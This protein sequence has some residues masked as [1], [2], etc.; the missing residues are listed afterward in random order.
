[1][2]PVMLNSS[3]LTYRQRADAALADAS[4]GELGKCLG[5]R[6][7]CHFEDGLAAI[8]GGIAPAATI[9]LVCYRC[10]QTVLHFAVEH[11]AKRMVKIAAEAPPP[12]DAMYIN[13]ELHLRSRHTEVELTLPVRSEPTS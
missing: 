10:G 13:G 2:N 9:A 5:L 6:P 4:G 3:I 11:D 8:F 7:A 12:L 1:M